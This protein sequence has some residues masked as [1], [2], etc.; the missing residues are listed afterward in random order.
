M[1]REH[2]CNSWIVNNG[3][4][5]RSV[6]IIGFQSLFTSNPCQHPIVILKDVKFSDL[7]TMVDFMY[8][9]EVNVSQDQLPAILKVNTVL[10]TSV[11]DLWVVGNS[12]DIPQRVFLVNKF[13]YLLMHFMFF[14]RLKPS[15][16]RAS[17]KCLSSYLWVNPS[18]LTRVTLRPRFHPL[19]CGGSVCGNRPPGRDPS[20]RA[21]TQR[22]AAALI[23]SFR[24][25]SN[26]KWKKQ[27]WGTKRARNP[28]LPGKVRAVLKTNQQHPL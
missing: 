18:V 25:Q 20:K 16:S 4:N 6:I 22:P 7:K 26:T 14:R 19:C 13:T 21:K 12:L 15:K 11:R 27:F 2:L 23:W 10:P 1:A 9:G 28:N 5:W 24:P 8:Y 3:N 17:P